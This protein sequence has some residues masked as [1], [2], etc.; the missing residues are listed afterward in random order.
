MAG[1]GARVERECVQ[2]WMMADDVEIRIFFSGDGGDIGGSHS[3]CFPTMPL[4]GQ[5]LVFGKPTGEIAVYRVT[6]TGFFLWDDGVSP[7]ILVHPKAG[8]HKAP[9]GHYDPIARAF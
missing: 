9:A 2:E 4:I 8:E 3:R 5:T 1:I 7:W 6:E